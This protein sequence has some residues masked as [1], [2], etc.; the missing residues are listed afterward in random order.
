VADL[1]EIN[2]EIL[3]WA[4]KRAGLSVLDAAR[5]LKVTEGQLEDLERGRITPSRSLLKRIAATYRRPLVTF[6]MA[7]PPKAGPPVG[8]FRTL[9]TPPPPEERAL[10]EALVRDVRAR[11]SIA[12]DLLEGDED[13]REL[14]FVGKFRPND[15]IQVVADDIRRTLRVA[16]SDQQ[17]AGSAEAL[18]KL[19]RAKTESAGVFVLLIGDLGSPQHN[20]ISVETFRGYALVDKIAPFVVVNDRDAKAAYS[21]TL[22]HELAH[23]WIGAEGISGESGGRMMCHASEATGQSGRSGAAVQSCTVA[24]SS[25]GSCRTSWGRRGCSRWSSTD[26]FGMPA[27]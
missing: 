10:L 18:F 27:T 4:R 5:R 19:F 22:L 17:G 9:T 11:Q 15:G 13:V 12:R 21:F 26:G 23:L 7:S 8:D 24:V 25:L 3:E 14:P 1:V 2:P 20:S 16:Y 6:Y